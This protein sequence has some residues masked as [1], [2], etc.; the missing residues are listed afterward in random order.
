ML[1]LRLVS[2]HTQTRSYRSH[3]IS[4]FP[5]TEKLDWKVELQCAT[6]LGKSNF[7]VR[8]KCFVTVCERT[9]HL[10]GV[11]RNIDEKNPSTFNVVHRRKIDQIGRRKFFSMKT[12]KCGKLCK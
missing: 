10:G 8:M 4:Y 6:G 3:T 7:E 2:T 1:M 12:E 5:I 9:R 11:F